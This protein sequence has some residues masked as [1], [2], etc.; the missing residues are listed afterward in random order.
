MKYVLAV[1]IA[2]IG[3]IFGAFYSQDV[4]AWDPPED[5]ADEDRTIAGNRNSPC[6]VVIPDISHV[7]YRVR[8]VYPECVEEM[9]IHMQGS[10]APEKPPS[11]LI[12]TDAWYDFIWDDRSGYV[13]KINDGHVLDNGTKMGFQIDC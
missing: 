5:C 1:L 4:A 2:V 12:R 9:I 10:T 6:K 11:F 3:V 7:E 8:M 13:R